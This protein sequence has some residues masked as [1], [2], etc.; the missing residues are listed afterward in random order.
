M[1]T[2][3]HRSCVLCLSGLVGSSV[4]VSRLAQGGHTG[5]KL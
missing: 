4:S 3:E 5:V 2:F 1:Q